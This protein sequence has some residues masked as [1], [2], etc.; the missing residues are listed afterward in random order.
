MNIKTQREKKKEI[1]NLNNT[2]FSLRT[3]NLG[4]DSDI[5]EKEEII[6]ELKQEIF[7]LKVQ[8]QKQMSN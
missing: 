8:Q 7:Q 2:I 1:E 3:A 4:L 5:K 6:S